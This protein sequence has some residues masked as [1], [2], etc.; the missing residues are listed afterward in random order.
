M[1]VVVVVLLYVIKIML[2]LLFIVF[3]PLEVAHFMCRKDTWVKGKK[4]SH[5]QSNL[6]NNDTK[7]SPH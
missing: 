5:M 3:S 4:M 1:V 2:L 6:L 7:C